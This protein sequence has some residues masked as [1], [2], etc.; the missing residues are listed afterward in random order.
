M[1]DL[2]YTLGTLGFFAAMLVYVRGIGRLG[3]RSTLEE[4]R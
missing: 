4:G 3:E 2:L 1:G